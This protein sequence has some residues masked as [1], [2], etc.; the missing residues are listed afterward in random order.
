MP[1]ADAVTLEESGHHIGVDA[2]EELVALLRDLVAKPALR[3]SR[4]DP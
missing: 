3:A 2:R 4:G 1:Q